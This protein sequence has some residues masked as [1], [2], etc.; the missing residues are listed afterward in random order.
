M[1]LNASDIYCFIIENN[2]VFALTENDKYSVE[3]RLYKL[4]ELLP[5][6]FV[7]INQSSIANIKKNERFSSSFSGALKVVF[8]NGYIDYVSRRKLK[9]VKE[10]L[11]LRVKCS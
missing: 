4:E 7:K 6:N 11:G 8:K 1:K 3:M 5:E 9:K 2:K 10:K